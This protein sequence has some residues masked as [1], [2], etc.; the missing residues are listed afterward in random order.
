VRISGC[1]TDIETSDN[2]DWV[3]VELMQDDVSIDSCVAYGDTDT[4]GAFQVTAQPGDNYRL[5]LTRPGYEEKSVDVGT[6]SAGVEKSLNISMRQED[7]TIMGTIMDKNE[8]QP[9]SRVEVTVQQYGRQLCSTS[10]NS[11][12]TYELKVRPGTDYEVHFRRENYEDGY[13]V[14]KSSSSSSEAAQDG[15]HAEPERL[16]IK[17]GAEHKFIDGEIEQM[18]GVIVGCVVDSIFHTPVSGCRVL[19]QAKPGDN[20]NAAINAARD[21]IAD[22]NG[23]FQLRVPPG[24]YKLKM[25]KDCEMLEAEHIPGFWHP[26]VTVCGPDSFDNGEWINVEAGQTVQYKGSPHMC[27]MQGMKGSIR[28]R[29]VNLNGEGV[30]HARVVVLQDG[31]VLKSKPTRAWAMGS[32]DEAGEYVIRDLWPGRYK[33]KVEKQGYIT[34]FYGDVETSDA[35]ERGTIVE[36]HA[37]ESVTDINITLKAS[38]VLIFGQVVNDKGKGILAKVKLSDDISVNTNRKGIYKF[39]VEP[40]HYHIHAFATGHDDGHTEIT[41]RPAERG[42]APDIICKA[43][44]CKLQGSVKDDN[45][46]PVKNAAV[47]SDQG[48]EATTDDDGNYSMSVNPGEHQVTAE[49]KGYEKGQTTATVGAGEKVTAQTITCK[50]NQEQ[51]GSQP[52]FHISSRANLRDGSLLPITNLEYGMQLIDFRGGEDSMARSQAR[53]QDIPNDAKFCK[54][55]YEPHQDDVEA[56][57]LVDA[58]FIEVHHEV[59]HTP[60]RLTP[61]HLLF[62][63]RQTNPIRGPIPAAALVVGDCV[64]ALAASTTQ[65]VPCLSKVTDI[66]VVRDKGIVGAF[67]SSGRLFVEGVAVSSYTTTEGVESVVGQRPWLRSPYE[68]LAHAC[69]F[70]LR[71]LSYTQWSRT[72]LRP[73]YNN[74]LRFLMRLSTRLLINR[75]QRFHALLRFLPSRFTPSVLKAYLK[76]LFRALALRLQA[77]WSADANM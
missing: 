4:S 72:H 46:E 20:Y 58:D 34:T 12:G 75:T 73:A 36:V 6:L 45:G 51:A 33:V 60:L 48:G 74:F 62:V 76:V 32:E 13:Y 30:G 63:S 40:G 35:A 44:E 9:L 8:K 50:K 47:K 19:A 38:N 31:G 7:A 16:D 11:S 10:S 1:I 37:K 26:T 2:I 69:V 29:V 15:V 71:L 56:A 41:V 18:D 53:S 5:R 59:G 65:S 42:N 67:T 70:P 77:L 57:S 68:T 22:A 39:T 64:H 24:Q 23:C 55:I 3:T 17:P 52:C 21:G 61:D 27:H 66:K 28:G 43:Q 25:K 14:G 49:A 54:F